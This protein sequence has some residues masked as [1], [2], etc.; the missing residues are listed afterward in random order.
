MGASV[1]KKTKVI[2]N[3]H[4]G[5]VTCRR[6]SRVEVEKVMEAAGFNRADE[7]SAVRFARLTFQKA[8]TGWEHLADEDAASVVPAK[9]KEKHATLG[10]VCPVEVY[11]AVDAACVAEVVGFAMG[12]EDQAGN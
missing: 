4:G 1:T 3:A 7:A 6:L 2:P 11:E 8:V 12:R 5:T 10:E 9:D